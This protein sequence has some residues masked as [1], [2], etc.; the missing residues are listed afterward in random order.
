[1]TI[2][3]HVDV[4]SFLVLCCQFSN[5]KHQESEGTAVAQPTII[6]LRPYQ[7]IVLVLNPLFMLANSRVDSPNSGLDL[8]VV[9]LPLYAGNTSL[10]RRWTC[11][12]LSLAL[13]WYLR[14]YRDG[15]VAYAVEDS[16]LHHTNG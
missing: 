9:H 11:Y 3:K 8:L 4:S 2:Y 10:L 6:Q 7:R 14:Y 12:R 13:L 16:H 15:K 5:P 1:M